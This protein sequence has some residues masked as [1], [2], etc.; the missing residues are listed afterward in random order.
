[1]ET[2]EKRGPGRPVGSSK[3]ET[4]QEFEMRLDDALRGEQEWLETTPENIAY[5]NRRGLGGAKYFMYKGIKVCAYGDM[6]ALQAADGQEVPSVNFVT[7]LST[8]SEPKPVVPSP[9]PQGAA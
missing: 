5:F 1:M 3:K 8:G 7:S 6:E 4:I 9:G 2:E